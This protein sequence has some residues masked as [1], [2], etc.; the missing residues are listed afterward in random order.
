MSRL[1]LLLLLAL[2]ASSLFLIRSAYDARRLFADILY[3]I[4]DPRIRFQ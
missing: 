2:I 4:V 3:V 1:N